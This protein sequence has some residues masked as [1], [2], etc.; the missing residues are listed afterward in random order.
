MRPDW[1]RARNDVRAAAGRR[2]GEAIRERSLRRRRFPDARESL[3]GRYEPL[4]DS[5]ELRLRLWAAKAHD[6]AD[7][8]LISDDLMAEMWRRYR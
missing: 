7:S 8:A 6:T 5:Q 4:T 3:Q 2:G 1:I